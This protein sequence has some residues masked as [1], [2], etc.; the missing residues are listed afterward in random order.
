MFRV[1]LFLILPAVILPAQGRMRP[2]R[3]RPQLER[4]EARRDLKRDMIM[5]RIHQMRMNRIQNALG[6]SADK[7]R[8]ISDRWAQFDQ[9]SM[10]RRQDTRKLRE[11][12]NSILMGHGSEDEKNAKLRPM[13]DQLTVHQKQQQD[14]RQIFETDIR[15]A[16]TPAQQGRFI[17]LIEE[18][19]RS[20]QEAIAEQKNEK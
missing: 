7:A 8:A 19:Q 20:M 15:S 1:A 12:V 16:L 13:I 5:T 3:P 9:D 14:A 4:R 2:E 6:V 17:I 10:A 18:F 11:Q